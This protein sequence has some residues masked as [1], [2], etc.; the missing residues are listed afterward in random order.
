MSRFICVVVN[1][2]MFFLLTKVPLH[3]PSS[4]ILHIPS[5]IDGWLG[6]FHILAI[7]SNA[8]INME[9]H[10]SQ[11][12]IFISFGYI[13]RVE[14][15][16][17]MVDVFLI[18]WGTSMFSSGW[19]NLHSHQQCRSSPF[20]TSMPVLT[21]CCL[22]DNHFNRCDVISHCGLDLYFSDN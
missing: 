22:G 14:F 9:K 1:G 10:I 20:I 7:V 6:C 17:H 16:D 8:A 13:S 3:A 19:T 18:F 12:S 4:H 5:S 21:S 15:L 11:Y 2:R